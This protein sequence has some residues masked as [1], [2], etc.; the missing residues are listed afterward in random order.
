MAER[1]SKY[2]EEFQEIGHCGGQF[3]VTIKTTEDS[4]SIQFGYRHSRPTAMSMFA[5]YALPQGIPVGTIK[6]GGIGDPWNAP[7]MA[8]CLPIFI[9]SDSLGMFGHQCPQ[10]TG[11]WRSKGSFPGWGMTCPYCGLRDETHSFLTGGQLEYVASCCRLVDEALQSPNDGE[12]LIDMDQVSDAVG[13]DGNKPQFYYAD[14]SQQNKYDCSACGEHNDILGRYGYCSNCGTHNGH[15]ELERDISSVREKITTGQSYEFCV[16]DAVS[17][18]DSYARQ[19]AKQ[20]ANRVPMTSARRKEWEGKL[21]HNLRKRAESLD[22]GFGIKVFANLSQDEI[23]FAVLMF[24]RRH[25]YEHNGGEV[26][27]RYIRESGDTSV[28]PK[29]VIRESRDTAHRIAN[30]IIKMG[31][32]LHNGFHEMFPPEELPLKIWRERTKKE[33]NGPSEGGN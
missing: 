18:F 17:A 7:P 14:E 11:Y 31:R 4:R 27:E 30:L 23:E 3:T 33:A 12:H 21:F 19:I 28:R 8:G 22:A 13:T 20:I 29:Q 1:A 10:C 15:Q 26:D 32:N 24:Y 2:G 9:A 25:V 6:L 5:V 16:R